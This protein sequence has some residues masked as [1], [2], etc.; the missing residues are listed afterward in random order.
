MLLWSL[1]NCPLKDFF[2]KRIL[3]VL[4]L[5]Y[6]L[7]SWEFLDYEN[8]RIQSIL[9]FFSYFLVLISLL[10]F[11]DAPIRFAF[12]IIINGYSE[13]KFWNIFPSFVN[14]FQCKNKLCIISIKKFEKLV[15]FYSFMAQHV[16]ACI[17]YKRS[18]TNVY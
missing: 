10:S 16:K 4:D 7:T 13:S 5:I 9:F 11:L 3:P 14:D 15:A 6:P 12:K 2:I 18:N 1:L 17:G 8:E